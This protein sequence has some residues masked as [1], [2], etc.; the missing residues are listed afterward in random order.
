MKRLVW[1]LT[2][3]IFS[4]FQGEQE[5]FL[6]LENTLKKYVETD[7]FSFN[8]KVSWECD[9]DGGKESLNGSFMKKGNAFMQQQGKDRTVLTSGYLLN[10]NDRDKIII[11]GYSDSMPNFMEMYNL[12]KNDRDFVTASILKSEKGNVLKF[13]GKKDSPLA[14]VLASQ[15][16]LRADGWIAST[17][18]NYDK[19]LQEGF[20]QK[21]SWIKVDYAAYQIGIPDDKP[22]KLN[23][24]VSIKDKK[25][26][27]SPAYRSYQIVSSLNYETE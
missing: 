24:Y 21:C 12:F 2:F 1:I 7:N 3:F 5:A 9:G 26:T 11:I 23:T 17:Q 10:I 15:V 8:Y 14:Y 16:S 22:L 6:L 20:G 19:A 27:A 4:S 13:S 25:V 18:I